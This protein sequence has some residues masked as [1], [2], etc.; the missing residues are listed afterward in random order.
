MAFGSKNFA[1]RWIICYN[2]KET[3]T[4]QAKDSI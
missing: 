4:K 1:N 3:K 2:T